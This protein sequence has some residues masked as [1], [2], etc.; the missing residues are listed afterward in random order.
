MKT[1]KRMGAWRY[2]NWAGLQLLRKDRESARRYWAESR[3]A[4]Y[5]YRDRVIPGCD[6]YE[7][8]PECNESSARIEMIAEPTSGGLSK[9]EL[10]YLSLIGRH[11]PVR[12][13]FEIGTFDGCAAAHLAL[14]AKAQPGLNIHTLDL[15]PEEL[16]S[17]ALFSESD[18]DFIR[19][20]RPA[21]YIY[22]YLTSDVVE[23]LYGNSL[24]FDFSPYYQQM[25]LVFIDGNHRREFVQHDS[26]EALRMLRPGG[27][28]LWHDYYG[29]PGE[30][31]SDFL[32]EFAREH[33]LL[34]IRDTSLAVYRQPTDR[35]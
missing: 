2:L 14:N 21:Y 28:L 9:T 8:F 10:Y 6:F 30:D 20:M 12:Q 31:V 3:R 34:R 4:Y 29:I 33:A 19:Q 16:S 24:D 11:L 32:R 22:K 13:A 26:R 18:R 27:V 5:R 17:S 25:D 23:L 7:I 35:E 15:P 1:E